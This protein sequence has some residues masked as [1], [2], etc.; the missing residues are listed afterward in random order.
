MI[1]ILMNQLNEILIVW[2]IFQYQIR[3]IFLLRN[4]KFDKW[5]LRT[6][7][8]ISSG[9]NSARCGIMR[10]RAF[11]RKYDLFAAP[12]IALEIWILLLFGV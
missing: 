12:S 3:M 5:L 8:E 11:W 2:A 7:G 4:K 1:A 10:L 6:P 9:D